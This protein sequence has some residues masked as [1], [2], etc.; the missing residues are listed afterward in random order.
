[1]NI[2]LDSTPASE[3]ETGALIVLEFEGQTPRPGLEELY[4]SG[5]IA[6]KPQELT[7]VHNPAG[8]RA[9]RL[10][11]AGCGKPDKFDSA[12]LRR[13]V[14]AA[15]R[16]LKCKSVKTAALLLEGA[17][18]TPE[19]ASA[20][21]EGAVLGDFECDQRK[22]DR[23]GSKFL[24]GFSVAANGAGLAEAVERGRILAEAQ[25]FAREL[26]NE[27]PNVL[28]PAELARR[29]EAMAA[30]NGLACEVLDEEKL[31]EL[32]MGALLGVAMGS[33]QPPRLIILRYTPGRTKTSA[34]HLAIV[35]KGVTFDTG[36]ISIKPADNME[37]MKYDMAGGAAAIGAMQAIAQLKPSI[38][39]TAFVPAVENMPG[40][41]AQRPGDI[42]TTLSGKT[43]EVLNTD[44]EG[45][46][47][48]C[49]TF[50]YA[51]R[52]GCTHLIDAATLT[53]A[54]VVAL[55]HVNTGVFGNDENFVKR[56]MAAAAVEGE[57]MWQLPLD[58]E[59][60]E[61]LKSN[62]ADLHNI[63]GRYGGAI[64]AATFLKE[65]AD[66]LPWVHLDI[67][68]TAWLDDAKPYLAKGP[69][70]TPVRG[71]VRLAMDWHSD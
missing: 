54:V 57:K 20:A 18:A 23:S 65:F 28:N 17:Y 55:G 47:I 27:P 33:S 41:R 51:Q 13:T 71:F 1:M 25:N 50:T 19:N 63:G 5:E 48:L 35:G 3:L 45:R 40:G 14:G 61:L 2:H 15:V 9:A 8:Y 59:Y 67:A 29:A 69:T 32:G 68:G 22:S 34:P 60:K 4:R 31:R 7:L 10:A 30:A 43:V 62:F 36:G 70:G 44:A 42:V 46:M 38:P 66:P 16:A 39:V 37:K 56:W 64:T 12:A 6:G 53:G 24:T 49:D 26:A 52:L 11:L 21:V 58:E